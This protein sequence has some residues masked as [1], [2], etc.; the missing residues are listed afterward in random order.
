MPLGMGNGRGRPAVVGEGQ[1]GER[2]EERVGVSDSERTRGR[3]FPSLRSPTGLLSGRYPPYYTH[4]I[5]NVYFS[6]TQCILLMYTFEVLL[7]F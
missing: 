5:P 6:Y 1:V 4:I 2:V 3:W 7:Y